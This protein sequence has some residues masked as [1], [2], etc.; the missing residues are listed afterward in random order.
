M[1]TRSYT[2]SRRARID[3]DLIADYLSERSP[4]SARRVLIELRNTFRAL[5]ENSQLG[6]R[7]D[8]LRP[9]VRL[10]TPSRPASNYVIFFYPCPGGVE[11]SDVVH[12]A[13]DWEG[14][15]ARGER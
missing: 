6:T 10:F 15:F 4:E 13:Q 12:A 7:R 8:D 2:L 9:D 3:L 1:A 11:I 5:A 14:T